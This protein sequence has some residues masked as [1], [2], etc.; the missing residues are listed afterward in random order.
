MDSIIFA[1][2]QH[3]SGYSFDRQLAK[4]AQT[5]L[6]EAISLGQNREIIQLLGFTFWKIFSISH[7]EPWITGESFIWEIHRL[8]FD[9]DACSLIALECSISRRARSHCQ[10]SAEI[11]CF[12]QVFMFSSLQLRTVFLVGTSRHLSHFVAKTKTTERAFV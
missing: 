8:L 9:M 5:L 10:I 6:D 3:A 11:S 12:I 2:M 1:Y 7:S 4:L